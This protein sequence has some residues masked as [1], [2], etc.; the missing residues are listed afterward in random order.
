MLAN[1]D[2]IREIGGDL[3]VL[4]KFV[5]VYCQRH[6][7]DA[8][9]EAFTVKGI[10]VSGT[11]LGKRR[12]CPECRSLLRHAVAK[13]ARCPLE[14]KPACRVCP[15]HCYAPHMRERIRKV[16]A[17]SGRHLM[18]RGHLHLLFHFLERQPKKIGYREGCEPGRM[19]EADHEADPEVDPGA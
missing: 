13:R 3:N 14:P 7:G 18:L 1:D 15:V 8:E 6:H 16:M 4:G 5:A 2:R 9:R 12:V 19:H 10:D 17:F 11:S